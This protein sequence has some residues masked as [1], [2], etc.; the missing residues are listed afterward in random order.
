MESVEISAYS[1]SIILINITRSAIEEGSSSLLIAHLSLI[2]DSRV[3]E[4]PPEH[5][6]PE[7][8]LFQLIIQ[9]EY[10]SHVMLSPN[11]E[12]LCFDAPEFFFKEG[13]DASLK[14]ERHDP[15]SG[16]LQLHR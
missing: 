16:H 8:P 10:G 15:S 12:Y 1:V 11:L 5:P 3:P 13:L 4:N 14:P 6:P 7:L 2:P 9:L